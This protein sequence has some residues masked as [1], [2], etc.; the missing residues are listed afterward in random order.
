[1]DSDDE[2]EYDDNQVTNLEKIDTSN[3]IKLKK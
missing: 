2:E 3:Q 1:M